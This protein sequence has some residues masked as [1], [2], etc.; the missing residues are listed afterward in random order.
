MSGHIRDRW[1][2][3]DPDNPR[4]KIRTARYGKGKRWVAVWVEPNGDRAS[5]ACTTKD[6]AQAV[7]DGNNHQIRSGIYIP[8]EAGM[9][10][11][12]EYYVRYMGVQQH[13]RFNSR[14]TIDRYVRNAVLPTLKDTQMRSITRETIQSLIN[15]QNERYSPNTVKN[16]LGFLSMIFSAAV[17]D[18]VI[19]TSP[20]RRIKTPNVESRMTIMTPEEMLLMAKTLER[21][22]AKACRWNSTVGLRPSELAAVI[23]RN[24]IELED[25]GAVVRIDKQI[26]LHGSRVELKTPYSARDILVGP[27]SRSLLG[28]RG[29]GFVFRTIRG[30]PFTRK[31]MASA[32]DT[33]RKKNPAL[34]DLK[35]WHDLRHF[36]ASQLI[37]A[38][39]SPIAVARRL[40]HKDARE[41]LKTYSHLWPDDDSRMA[42]I[43]DQI[44]A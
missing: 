19:A 23:W 17:E 15:L 6:E 9:V 12:N 37:N 28:E 5:Q 33:A 43:G 35:G 40:G 21:D 34:R 14:I 44:I 1:M 20:V 24:I 10:T 4:K 26:D 8:V 18:R 22:F 32:W 30:G 41:T 42:S 29:E 31:S 27:A 7:L 2:K 38:G 16:G 3:Q 11:F 25:G 13:L 36:H 39:M